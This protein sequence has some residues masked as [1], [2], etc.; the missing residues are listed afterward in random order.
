[1][2]R[3]VSVLAVIAVMA[4]MVAVMVVPAFAEAQG[5]GPGNCIVPGTLFSHLAKQDGPTEYRG[6]PPG[7]GVKAEC[8]PAGS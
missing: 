4:A 5:K 7:Q 6:G 8:T 2:R 1:M 3:I